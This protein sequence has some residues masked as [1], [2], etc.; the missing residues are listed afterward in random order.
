[1]SSVSEAS[2]EP[3]R[4]GRPRR[5]DAK[6][7]ECRIIDAATEMFVE[8]GFRATTIE[9]VA[10][11]ANTTRRSVMTRFSDKGQLFLAV[12]KQHRARSG[13]YLWT[14]SEGAAPIEDYR[15]VCRRMLDF[16]LTPRTVAM[17]RIF[18]AEVEAIPGLSETIMEWDD[19]NAS[20]IE[21]KIISAQESGYFQRQSASSLATMTIGVMG[22]N[23]MNRAAL[24]DPQFSDARYIDLY[25]SQMWAM[26]ML[27]A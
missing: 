1:M 23:P 6:L 5:S 7:L 22:S 10:A 21:K 12:A 17:F 14:P 20:Q 4:S 18:A 13:D 3:L 19:Y 2:L 8:E 9:R 25:F 16:S 24:L 11:A 26:F 27:M 15:Q